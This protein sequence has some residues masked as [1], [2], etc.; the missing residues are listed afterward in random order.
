[1]LNERGENVAEAEP[2]PAGQV[3]GFTSVP[4]AGDNF[5]VVDEDRVAR[6]IAE[7]RAAA[8]ATPPGAE[9]WPADARVA[10]RPPQG[11]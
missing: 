11:G 7:Q 8:S 10:V 3:L 9:P 1:M 6:Q 5:L 2:G 4:G